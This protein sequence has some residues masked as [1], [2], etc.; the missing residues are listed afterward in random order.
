MGEQVLNQQTF[1]D[2]R[3]ML[4]GLDALFNEKGQDLLTMVEDACAVGITIKSAIFT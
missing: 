2:H 3:S 1:I 4:N